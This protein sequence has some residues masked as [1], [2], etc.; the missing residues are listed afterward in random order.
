MI[1]ANIK[2]KNEP[3]FHQNTSIEFTDSGM[4]LRVSINIPYYLIKY[5]PCC[6]VSKGKELWVYALSKELKSGAIKKERVQQLHNHLIKNCM[7]IIREAKK[8][9]LNDQILKIKNRQPK[10][11][12]FFN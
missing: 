6:N 7:I 10:Q 1:T 4:I 12:T 8:K 11:L 9:H 3:E 2:I 5:L